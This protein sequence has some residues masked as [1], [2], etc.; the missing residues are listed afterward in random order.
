MI[1]ASHERFE[2]WRAPLVSLEFLERLRLSQNQVHHRGTEDTE[3][4]IY[5][6]VHREIPM[7][8]KN[9]PNQIPDTA[10]FMV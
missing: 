4:E 8:G 10:L 2:L 3:R 5:V 9:L 1:G 7:D 6:S